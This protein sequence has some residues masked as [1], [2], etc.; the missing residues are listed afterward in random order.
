MKLIHAG[1]LPAIL[2]GRRI[3]V[4]LEPALAKMHALPSAKRSPLP[5]MYVGPARP[6]PLLPRATAIYSTQ[7]E[8]KKT[9]APNILFCRS[10][11]CDDKITDKMIQQMGEVSGYYH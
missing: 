11:I 3:L 10:F 4:V 6:I 8:P 5:Q 9:S 7:S 2:L 1:D